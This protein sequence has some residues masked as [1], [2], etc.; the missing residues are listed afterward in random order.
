MRWKSYSCRIP[1]LLV[2]IFI[3][4]QVFSVFSL[5]G[6]ALA[7]KE[8]VIVAFGDSLTA[9]LGV[10]AEQTYPAL[11][12]KKLKKNGHAFHVVNS[13]VSGETTAG[14]LRRIGWILLKMEP[15]IVILE[16][17][18]NDGLRGLSLH[19]MEKNLAQII[20]KLQ[21]NGVAV[22]LAGMKVPPN[23]GKDYSNRFEAVYP[24]LAAQYNL[25]LIPFFL[26]G[27]AARSHLN[28]ADGIHPTAAGYQIITDNIWPIIKKVISER[29]D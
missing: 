3:N 4:L 14:G 29:P 18:A 25:P 28:Q 22:I 12:A 27:V 23:Y 15:D 6:N 8:R 17:G 5:E 16:L 2:L 10:G 11:L 7:A 20:E 1:A 21:S 26:E 19:E 9:G 24:A 13:G